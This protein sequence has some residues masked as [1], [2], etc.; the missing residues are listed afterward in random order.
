MRLLYLLSLS[1]SLFYPANTD[2][3]INATNNNFTINGTITGKDTGRVVLWYADP[4]QQIHRDTS[5]LKNGNYSFNGIANFAGEALLWTDINNHIYDHQTMLRFILEPGSIFISCNNEDAVHAAVTG[6]KAQIEKQQWDQQ[7]LN[8]IAQKKQQL[9]IADSLYKLRKIN[10]GTM[11]K[12]IEASKY[13]IINMDIDYISRQHN[14]YLSGYLLSQHKRKIS[15]DSLQ[16]LYS[17]LTDKVKRS[18]VG[19]DILSYLYPLTSDITFRNLNPI[20]G[21]NFD[22]RLNKINS[23]YDISIP[24]SSGN[25][26]T[27]SKFKGQ[28]VIIDFWASWCPPCI[29]NIPYIKKLKEDYK[30]DSLQI[31]SYSV[32]TDGKKWKAAIR[33]YAFF[34]TQ[35]SDLNGFYGLLPVYCKLAVGVPRYMLFDKLGNQINADLPQPGNPELNKILDGILK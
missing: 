21:S 6:S 17:A 13:S 12:K 11:Y 18:N 7:K 34:G 5:V 2:G 1:L 35:V 15:V 22:S 10:A 30:N 27:L 9:K 19:F 33:K 20:F 28:Y 25:M 3:Q 14:S 32:D 8:L 29:E 23:I 16:M 26:I 4:Q 31:L 24:D